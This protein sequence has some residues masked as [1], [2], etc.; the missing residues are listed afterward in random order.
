MSPLAMGAMALYQTSKPSSS[1]FSGITVSLWPPYFVISV[2][3]NVLLTVTIAWR[4]LLHE[5]NLGEALG[6]ASGINSIYTSVVTVLV[7]SCAIYAAA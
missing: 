4:L 3:L 7:E 5:R 1:L 6:Y 2:A